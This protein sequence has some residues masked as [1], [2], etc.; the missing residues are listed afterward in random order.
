MIEMVNPNTRILDEN[1]DRYNKVKNDIDSEYGKFKVIHDTG[2]RNAD[3]YANEQWTAAEKYS[4]AQQQRH[5][6]VLNEIS[7][8]IEHLAGTQMQTRTDTKVIP[9]EPG[10]AY[11]AEILQYMVKWF[12]QMND[13]E[14]LESEVFLDGIIKGFGAAVI[15]WVSTDLFYGSPMAE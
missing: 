6:Y 8:K 7:H 4:F 11:K 2:Y 1:E 3:Y 9:R 10:D 12:E 15:R 14:I 5:P 13:L